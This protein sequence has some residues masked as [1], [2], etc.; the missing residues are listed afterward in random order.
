MNDLDLF[1]ALVPMFKGVPV[2]PNISDALGCQGG[3][4]AKTQEPRNCKG[5]K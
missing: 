4:N 2:N 5:L 3:N 1:E